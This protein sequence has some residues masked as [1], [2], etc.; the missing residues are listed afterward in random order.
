MKIIKTTDKHDAFDPSNIPIKESDI[1]FIDDL[2]FLY[3]GLSTDH[4]V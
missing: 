2:P 1:V 4:L 3:D